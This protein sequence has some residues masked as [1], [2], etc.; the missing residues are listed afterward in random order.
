MSSGKRKNKGEGTERGGG[1]KGRRRRGRS[2]E[3]VRDAAVGG[4]IGGV[5]RAGVD[6]LRELI[7]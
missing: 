2:G 5:V 3:G 6:W 7:F 4:A 1:P